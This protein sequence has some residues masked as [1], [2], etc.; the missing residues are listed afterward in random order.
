M[1][2]EQYDVILAR[3]VADCRSGGDAACTGSAAGTVCT[4]VKPLQEGPLGLAGGNNDGGTALSTHPHGL[5]PVLYASYGHA[6]RCRSLSRTLPDGGVCYR[7][8]TYS[9]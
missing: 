5:G 7:P 2:R 9:L 1:A 6:R 8:G 4:I 3:A